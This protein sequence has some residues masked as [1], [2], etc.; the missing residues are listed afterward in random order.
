MKV[1][2][3]L[4]QSR[5]GMQSLAPL[6]TV[7]MLLPPLLVMIQSL[8]LVLHLVL[9]STPTLVMTPSQS[10]VVSSEVRFTAEVVR[11]RFGSLMVDPLLL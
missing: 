7:T 3:V 2:L 11:I 1:E 8:W 6:F 5:L 4:T 9:T 10:M